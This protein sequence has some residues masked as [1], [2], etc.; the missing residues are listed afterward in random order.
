[1]SIIQGTANGGGSTSFYPNPIDQ[2]L[3]FNDND[4][5]YLSKAFASDSDATQ[6]TFSFW[7]KRC[8]LSSDQHIYQ[9]RDSTGNNN[10]RF[11]IKNQN[12][13]FG[14]FAYDSGGSNF[15]NLET[16]PLYRD[17][18]AWYHIVLKI[19][20]TQATASDRVSLYVNGEEVTDFSSTTYPS[21]N[22]TIRVANSNITNIGR[23]AGFSSHLD[24]YLAE[25]HFTDGT[26][27]DADAFG[28]FKEGVWV[29]KAP[30][31]TYGTN[32]FYLDFANSA[33]LHCKRCGVG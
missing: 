23:N 13:K 33:D 1:M 11:F 10:N 24:G 27:Y 28:E 26:A 14:F 15:L 32:G 25:V 5:A 7:L 12:D 2:S 20:T 16:T 31:V 18:S 29:A 22:D 21:Q 4:S 6:A 30:S 3:R 8:A 19:D 9:G 17:V